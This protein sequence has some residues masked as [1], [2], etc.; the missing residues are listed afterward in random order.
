MF[1][2]LL[3]NYKDNS[4][5]LEG[6]EKATACVTTIFLILQTFIIV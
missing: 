5:N 6:L 3:S 4:E 2:V 1:F